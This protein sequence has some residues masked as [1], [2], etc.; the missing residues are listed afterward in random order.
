MVTVAHRTVKSQGRKATATQHDKWCTKTHEYPPFNT[1]FEPTP[2]SL[3]SFSSGTKQSQRQAPVGL[4]LVEKYHTGACRCG[5]ARYQV[6]GEVEAFF[7]HCESCRRSSGAPYVA[8]GRV[9]SHV[10]RLTQGKL[11][12]FH[13]APKV[14]RG[15]CGV[16]GTG[17]TYRNSETVSILEFQL[18]TLDS[19]AE[20]KPAYHV[21]VS[22]QLPW[23]QISDGLSLYREWRPDVA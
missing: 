3:A 8:W 22:E 14:I 6:Q 16:C 10:F 15:F 13:S 20:V 1:Q 4:V 19:P 11:T 17:I 18:A 9:H 21:W 2:D 12:E 7:C 5:A 23:V